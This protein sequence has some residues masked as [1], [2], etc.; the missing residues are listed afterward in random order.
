M[1]LS[2]SKINTY[3]KCPLAFRF[4]YIEEIEGEPNEYMILGRDVHSV[5][6]TFADRFGDELEK[7]N[8]E[9]ELIKI[10]NDLDIGY[11]ISEHVDNLGSFFREVFI[12]NDYKL[13][14]QEEYLIDEENRFSFHKSEDVK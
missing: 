6:E 2:K 13:F 8:I 10:T 9:N 12:D 7:V 4:Q 3:L 11:D 1:R 5:A 14:T